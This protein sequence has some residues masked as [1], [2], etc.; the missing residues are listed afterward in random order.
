MVIKWVKKFDSL[1]FKNVL[2]VL[3]ISIKVNCYLIMMHS[4]YIKSYAECNN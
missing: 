1:K 2:K 3:N 4:I